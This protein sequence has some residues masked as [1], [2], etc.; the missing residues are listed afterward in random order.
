VRGEEPL[1]IAKIGARLAIRDE[2]RA[3][4]VAARVGERVARE[5]ANPGRT[6]D[7]RERRKPRIGE[8][9]GDDERR[10][11]RDDMTARRLRRRRVCGVEAVARDEALLAALVDGDARHRDAEALREGFE[12]TVE[13]EVG[14]ARHDERVP[15][16]DPPRAVRCRST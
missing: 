15:G 6:G 12:E 9:V 14:V 5:E 16:C 8:R 11:V 10:A 1:V 2:E 7:E 13:R 4:D 3:P